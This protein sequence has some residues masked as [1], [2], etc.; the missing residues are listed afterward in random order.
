MTSQ[1]RRQLVL[2]V[3]REEKFRPVEHAPKELVQTLADLLLE[4]LG[5][6]MEERA[7]TNGGRDESED[8]V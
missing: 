2:D 3:R 4:A 1:F 8:H 6:E 5:K 7:S